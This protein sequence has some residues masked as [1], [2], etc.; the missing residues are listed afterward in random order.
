MS[1]DS[2]FMTKTINYL[3][4]KMA[5]VTVGTPFDGK[6]TFVKSA[7]YGNDWS[8]KIK[9]GLSDTV[10]GGWSG[11]RMNPYSLTDLYVNPSYQYDAGWFDATTVDLT[12]NVKGQDI[13]MNL[14]QWSDALNGAVITLNGVD[15]NFG[16]GMADVDTRLDIL[17]ACETAILMTYDYIPM[18][19][20]AGAA[21]LSKQ[22]FYVVE[23]WNPVMGRGGITYMKYNYDD[24]AW[25][26]YV[27][28]QGGELTY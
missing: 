22:V 9:S 13:T 1:S 18:L 6:I 24:A 20:D 10:L 2:D 11:S 27:A 8:N 12:I 4:E 17:A 3:N 7:P 16:D 15:Y 25:A 19:Q 28:S 21:L 26:E 5:E 14:K 23:D